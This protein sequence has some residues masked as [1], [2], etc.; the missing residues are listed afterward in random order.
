V[1]EFQELGFE[2]GYRV[3]DGTPPSECDALLDRFLAEAIAGN[4]LLVGG[5]AGKSASFFATSAIRR[6][7]AT[8]SH[9]NAVG[10]WLARNPRVASFHVGPLRD[11]WYGWEG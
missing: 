10:E 6:Q 3:A 11:A 8:D 5:G 7:S 1:G 4:G 2:V 9:R